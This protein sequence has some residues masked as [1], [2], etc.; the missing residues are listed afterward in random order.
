MSDDAKVLSND[1]GGLDFDPEALR[2][3]YQAERDKRV[4]NDGNEQYV[5]IAGRF[6]PL[7]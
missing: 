5:G 2:A 3:R 7:H 6:Q 4:R 1:N